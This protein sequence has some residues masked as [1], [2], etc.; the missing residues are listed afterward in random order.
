MDEKTLLEGVKTGKISVDS[1]LLALKKK[2]FEDPGYAKVD[3]H[4]ALRQ[5]AAEVIYGAVSPEIVEQ[6]VQIVTNAATVYIP[7]S[8]MIDF[9][10]ELA[11][12]NKERESTLGEIQ[13]IEKKLSNEGFVAKAPAAVVEGEREKHF[14]PYSISFVRTASVRG[15]SDR[16]QFSRR[17]FVLFVRHRRAARLRE[18]LLDV[19]TQIG[20]R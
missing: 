9:E 3:L 15:R 14:F 18:W 8:D 2:P 12:L 4:R 6:S 1:A 13:R 5:G 11:R 16:L 19:W 20:V 17:R 7:L 10:K